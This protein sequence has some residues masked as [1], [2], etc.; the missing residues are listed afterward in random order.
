[1]AQS[2]LI[3]SFNISSY[4]AKSFNIDVKRRQSEF[5][6]PFSSQHSSYCGMF[7]QRRTKIFL[8]YVFL[9]NEMDFLKQFQTILFEMRAGDEFFLCLGFRALIFVWKC[10]WIYHRSV[11]FRGI[12][13]NCFKMSRRRFIFK[14]SDKK[15]LFCIF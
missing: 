8:L 7:M 1:M 2:S 12:A 4:D 13:W 10:K 5:F 11:M 15:I 14:I 6:F 9:A 3:I